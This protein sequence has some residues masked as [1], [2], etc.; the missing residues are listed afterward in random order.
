MS[1]NLEQDAIKPEHFKGKEVIGHV[2]EAQAR[3]LIAATEI[4]GTEPTG[5][6]SA[7][8]DAAKDVA[9]VI[10]LVWILLMEIAMPMTIIFLLMIVFSLGLIVWKTGRSAWLGWSRLERLHRVLAEEKWEID[11][12]REQEREE[13]GVLYAAKGFEGKLL[14]D[15]L[16]VLMADGDRLLKVMVEEELGLS[17]QTNEHPLKQALGAFLG[18]L[19]ASICCLAGFF[20]SPNFGLIAGSVVIITTSAGLSAYES[21]NRLIP[22]II[23]NMGLLALSF[24]FVYSIFKFLFR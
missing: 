6:V 18:A 16:D 1:E 10:L 20:L 13:L 24:G 11:H 5:Y 21:K 7:A 15:V 17:L 3:G 9:A 4:H 19:I 22:A 23:W 2:A 12:H 14:E 8:S